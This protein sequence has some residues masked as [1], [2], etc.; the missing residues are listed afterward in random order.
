MLIRHLKSIAIL[1]LRFESVAHGTP[2]EN[3]TEWKRE[4]PLRIPALLVSV[5]T[6]KRCVFGPPLSRTC[7]LLR[8]CTE[9]AF[10]VA[11]RTATAGGVEDRSNSSRVRLCGASLFPRRGGLVAEANAAKAAILFE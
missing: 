6:Y 8:L 9:F 4:P 7:S 10:G 2:L 11:T 1:R 3:A 5:S